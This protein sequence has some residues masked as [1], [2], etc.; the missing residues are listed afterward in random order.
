ML[1]PGWLLLPFVWLGVVFLVSPPSTS[2]T[3]FGYVLA[4]VVGVAIA[5]F[6]RV[7]YHTVVLERGERSVTIRVTRGLA[8]ASRASQADG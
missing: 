5:A 4:I 2:A 1:V 7:Y 3:W 6:A 8:R